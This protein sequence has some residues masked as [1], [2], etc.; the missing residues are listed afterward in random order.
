MTSA[1]GS[2]HSLK[3]SI[4]MLPELNW[5]GTMLATSPGPYVSSPVHRKPDNEE[6]TPS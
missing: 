3:Q 5:A 4:A 2:I 6:H 1:N